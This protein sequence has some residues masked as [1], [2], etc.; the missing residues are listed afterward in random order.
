[1]KHDYLNW[2]ELCQQFP[3]EILKE[4]DD[5]WITYSKGRFGFN[6]QKNIWKKSG[7]GLDDGANSTENYDFYDSPQEF[8]AWITFCQQVE[9]CVS[10]EWILENPSLLSLDFLE[11]CSRSFERYS[12]ASRERRRRFAWWLSYE[13]LFSLE[14]YKGELAFG[15]LPALYAN[16]HLGCPLFRCGIGGGSWGMRK[17]LRALFLHPALARTD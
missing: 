5:L 10:E 3:N 13:K 2:F 12:N 1:L 14:K 11:R 8:E 16:G 17:E 7:G 4:I 9:W 6:I 15:A